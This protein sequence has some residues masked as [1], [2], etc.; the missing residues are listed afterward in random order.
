MKKLLTYL[1]IG[2]SIITLVGCNQQTSAEIVTTS[3]VGYDFT[4][5]VVGN[6]VTVKLITPIGTD[7]HHFEPTSKDLVE[8]KKSDVFVYLGFDYDTW[9]GNESTLK[10]YLNKNAL[11]IDLSEL[12]HEHEEDHDHDHTY[13]ADEIHNHDHEGIHLHH[14]GEHFWT[15]PEVAILLINELYEKLIIKY[16]NLANKFNENK[17][18]Y[19]NDLENISIDFKNYLLDLE[20]KTLFYTGHMALEGFASYFNLTIR[21][22]EETLTPG[23]DLTSEEI[24]KFVD[25]M[26]SNNT[27]YLFTEELQAPQTANAIKQLLGYE[28]KVYE[29]HGYHQVSSADFNNE[30]TY[31]DLLQRNVNFIKEALKNG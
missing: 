11:A 7:F 22:L 13:E 9:L 16:P 5:A 30:V 15:N 3:Y 4:K 24:K 2:I 19:I 26:K 14:H 1:L 29:L 28:I 8:I 10:N 31:K 25:E 20:S 6:D 21:A 23:T 12:Y 17:T 27:K 18:A